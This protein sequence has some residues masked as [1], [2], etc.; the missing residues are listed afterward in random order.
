MSYKVTNSKL[1]TYRNKL[2]PNEHGDIIFHEV[3]STY[4]RHEEDNHFYVHSFILTYDE[5]SKEEVKVDVIFNLE[6]EE[7]ISKLDTLLKYQ[8]PNILSVI[9]EQKNQIPQ[10]LFDLENFRYICYSYSTETEPIEH[11]VPNQA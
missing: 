3:N 6:T 1:K 8:L 7:H 10:R 4:Y 9:D 2:S 5:K 11:V